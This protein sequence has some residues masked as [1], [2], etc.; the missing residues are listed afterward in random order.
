MTKI[1]IELM[2]EIKSL[3][4]EISLILRK[5]DLMLKALVPEIEPSKEEI[6]II[7]SKKEYEIKKKTRNSLQ[8]S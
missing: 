4:R 8:D 6:K 2:K 5:Q 1:E 3:R 7:K